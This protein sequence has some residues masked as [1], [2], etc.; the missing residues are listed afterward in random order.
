L[1]PLRT[2][3]FLSKAEGIIPTKARRLHRFLLITGAVALAVALVWF[4]YWLGKP[5]KDAHIPDF[6]RQPYEPF[7]RE[8]AV[9]ITLREWRLFDDLV[10]DSTP[11]QVPFVNFGSSERRD[12]L[13]QRVGEYWWLGLD[14]DNQFRSLTGKHDQH[15]NVFPKQHDELYA[16]SAVF[17]SYI[18]RIAGAGSQ[19]PYSESHS[20]YINEASKASLGLVPRRGVLAQRLELYT[21]QPGDLVCFGRNENRGLRFEDLPSSH[22]MAHCDIV[23]DVRPGKISV[24]GGNV[25]DA[26]TLKHVPVTSKGRL[27]DPSGNVL[28]Q[29]YP[30][31]VVIQVLYDR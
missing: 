12:G 1:N 6:A 3:P 13:W 10:D 28:D 18:M 30:W 15:G 7:S 9:A 14:S 25:D 11:G 26:V 27:A 29:R 31:C 20:D 17:I 16:W 21:P 4:G 23:V 19:F 5:A 22:F 24:V 8:A 2:A